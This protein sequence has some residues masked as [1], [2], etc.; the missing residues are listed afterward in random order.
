MH[1]PGDFRG[2]ALRHQGEHDLVV[3]LERLMKSRSSATREAA[4]SVISMRPWPTWPLPSQAYAAPL[5]F[6]AP[7]K[8]RFIAGSIFSPRR[9][10]LPLRGSR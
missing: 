1:R 4:A 5:P 9:P 7:L 6:S 3:G 8:L 10:G 2:L